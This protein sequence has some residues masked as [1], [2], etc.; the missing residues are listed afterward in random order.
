MSK[1]AKE[2]RKLEAHIKSELAERGLYKDTDAVKLIPQLYPTGYNEKKIPF[3]H[4]DMGKEDAERGKSFYIVVATKEPRH[5]TV[6][7]NQPI[8][9]QEFSRIDIQDILER[10]CPHLFP[11]GSEVAKG[12]A[13]GIEKSF[14]FARDDAIRSFVKKGAVS[15]SPIP[16]GQIMKV[17]RT[18]HVSPP[19]TKRWVPRFVLGMF[20][21]STTR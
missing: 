20:V 3:F 4:L 12:M 19:V 17:D 1:Q 11:P 2:L 21:T 10:Q 14:Y 7:V 9:V 18:L 15:I 16:V 13:V 8:M 6:I 5:S